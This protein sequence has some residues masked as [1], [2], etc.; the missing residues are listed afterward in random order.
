LLRTAVRGTSGQRSEQDAEMLFEFARRLDEL[1]AED[2][3]RAMLPR[4]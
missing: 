1:L 3:P 4:Q 2:W